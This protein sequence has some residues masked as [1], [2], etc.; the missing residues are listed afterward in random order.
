[1]ADWGSYFWRGDFSA[2]RRPGRYRAVALVGKVRGESFPFTVSERAVLRGTGK[3]GVDFFFVQRCGCDVPGWH[4]ACHLD[5]ARLPDGSPIDATGG[6][7]SAGD[8][9]KLM[10]ENGDGGVAYA[11]LKAYDAFP[12]YFRPFDRDHDGRPDILDEA[13]WG[14]RFVAKMQNPQTG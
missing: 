11:L 8:Y 5:D 1:T 9:N 14:A 12:E 10:Y 3:L 4:P 13:L 7:H 2:L 6:W